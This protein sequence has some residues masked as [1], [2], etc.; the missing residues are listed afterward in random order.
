MRIDTSISDDVTVPPHVVLCILYI[1]M[2]EAK[3]VL[4]HSS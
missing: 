2:D 3:H 1:G 4:G